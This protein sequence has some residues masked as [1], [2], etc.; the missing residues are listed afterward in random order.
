MRLTLFVGLLLTCLVLAKTHDLRY[1]KVQ[2]FLKKYPILI[3]ESDMVDIV[4]NGNFSLFPH[5]EPQIALPYKDYSKGKT[6]IK[7]NDGK[8]HVGYLV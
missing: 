8:S 6:V 4:E 3:K 5:R 2:E 1:S 7:G